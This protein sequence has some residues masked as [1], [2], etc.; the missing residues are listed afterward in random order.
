MLASIRK[1]AKSWVAAV[2]IGLLIISFAVFGI[3]DVFQGNVGDAVVKAGSRTVTSVDF[4]REFDNYKRGLEQQSGQPVTS[5]M[6]AADGRDRAFLGQLATR[7]AFSEVLRRAGIR[8]SDALVVKQLEGIPAF[9]D[10]VSGRF[11]KAT[12]AQRLGEVGLTPEG[13]DQVLRDEMADEQFAKAAAN[14]LRVPRAYTAL[15]AIYAMEARDLSV[16][17]LPR[18]AVPQPEAPTDAQLTAFMKENTARLTRPEFRILTVARFSPELVSQNL[19][20]DQAELQKRFEFRRDTLSTPETRTVLQVPAKDAP[21]AQQIMAR[22]SRGEPPAQV[23]KAVGVDVITYDSKPQSA[24][25]DRR[26][27]EAAFKMRA[28]EIASVQGDLGMAVVRVVS[29]TPGRQVS[30]ADVRPMIEAEL[31]KDAAAEKVYA[32][33]QAYE[34]AHQGGADLIQSAQKAGVAATTMGPLSREGRDLQGQPI[35]GL[36]QKIV[37]QAFSLPSGGESDLVEAGNGE[38]FAVRI[39]RVMPP[40]V[41]PLAEI[42]LELAQVWMARE[43]ASRM[44]ARADELAARVR[45]G[46]SLEAAATSVG[47]RVSRISGLNRE[48]AARDRSLPQDLVGAAFAAKSG[49]VFT[50]P[51]APFGYAIA[52]LD[53]INAAAGPTSARNAEQGRPQMSMAIFREI[54]DTARSHARQSVK[55]RTDYDRARAALGLEPLQPAVETKTGKAK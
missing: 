48:I 16:F 32:L 40:A 41:P 28:G 30:L 53:R 13:F 26:V 7:E 20:I 34:D 51:A 45:R 31:R 37:E 52:K 46:E 36:T 29:V 2:L 42:R 27:G 21:T 10:Q 15:A 39:D 8:P 17:I 24:I 5:E 55:V 4:R 23:A 11:D 43:V 38:Y 19:P 25:A 47:S 12:Y 14:G 33:T 18:E 9:F 22:L 54:G 6:A 1:F 49:E 3:N 35:P 50:S 44:R